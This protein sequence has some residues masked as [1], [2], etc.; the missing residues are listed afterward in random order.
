MLF[1]DESSHRTFLK[2]ELQQLLPEG[3]FASLVWCSLGRELH[4]RLIEWIW[5][6]EVTDQINPVEA[7]F[8]WGNNGGLDPEWFAN[9]DGKYIDDAGNEIPPSIKPALSVVEQLA[10]YGLWLLEEEYHSLGAIEDESNS[11]HVFLTEEELR[12]LAAIPE[13]EEEKSNEQEWTRSE[14]I[15]HRRACVVL[16][17]QALAYSHR[18]TLTAKE[19]EKATQFLSAWGKAGGKKRHEKMAKLKAWV[20]EKYRAGKSN[21]KEWDSKRQASIALVNKVMD[22]CETIGLKPSSPDMQDRIYRWI[23]AAEKSMVSSR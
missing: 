13:E 12:S 8:L 23:L 5:P 20:I 7:L 6:D 3:S 4:E 14:I 19:K 17:Y 9:E 16:A 11:A 22:Y 10:A 1:I 21:S 15:E 18:T 2:Q